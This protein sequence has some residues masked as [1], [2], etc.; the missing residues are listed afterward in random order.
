MARTPHG[1]TEIEYYGHVS[2][3]RKP[4]GGPDDFRAVA[5]FTDVLAEENS[6][7]QI[8]LNDDV[9]GEWRGEAGRRGDVTL[10]WGRPL[11]ASAS[12]ATAELDTHT[13]DQ[14]PVIDDRFTLLAV[15]AVEGFGDELYL[16]VRLWSKRNQ[17]LAAESLYAPAGQGSSEETEEATA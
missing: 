1:E 17:E 13:V 6:D 9:V 8:D 12:A 3:A 7:W 15:D 2:F 14:T 4:E 11:I 10:V 5:D 16:T